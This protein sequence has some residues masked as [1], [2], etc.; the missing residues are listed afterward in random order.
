MDKKKTILLS[1]LLCMAFAILVLLNSLAVAGEGVR[2]LARK[3]EPETLMTGRDDADREPMELLPGEL[4]DIN[5]ATAAQLQ[6]LPGIG[7][8]LAQAIIDYRETEGS[9]R[10]IEELT[11]VTGIGQGRYEAVAELITVGEP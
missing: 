7:E 2:I 5:T 9:F 11:K 3:A 1:L 4:V 8:V 6:K 10:S